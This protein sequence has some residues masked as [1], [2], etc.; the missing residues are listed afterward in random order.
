MFD[1]F[2][3]LV[4]LF[5]QNVDIWSFSCTVCVSEETLTSSNFFC[6][7]D[8]P[9]HNLIYICL[10]KE[11]LVCRGWANLISWNIQIIRFIQEYKF[12]RETQFLITKLRHPKTFRYKHLKIEKALLFRLERYFSMDSKKKEIEVSLV[13]SEDLNTLRM[14]SWWTTFR[15]TEKGFFRMNS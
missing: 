7:L 9:K 4:D 13:S 11:K 15:F 14:K 6:S 2:D 8:H 3:L 12:A 10:I 1:H 5:P